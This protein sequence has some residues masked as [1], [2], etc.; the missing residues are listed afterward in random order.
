MM[1]RI[2]ISTVSC[3]VG[4][5]VGALFIWVS[6]Q[7]GGD[8]VTALLGAYGASWFMREWERQGP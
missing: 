6:L 5:A 4:L 7:I 2:A 8:P 1:R 3:G